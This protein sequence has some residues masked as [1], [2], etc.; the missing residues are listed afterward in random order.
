MKVA[1]YMRVSTVDQHCEVQARELIDYCRR[2]GWEVVADFRDEGISGKANKKRPAQEKLMN[3]AMLHKF[4][5]VIVWKLDRF[6]RSIM[7][8]LE[9]INKL[10]SWGVRF[11]AVSQNID[12]DSSNPT[13]GLLL[14]IM[15]AMAEFERELLIERTNSGLAHAR[16]LGKT[17]GRPRKVFRRDEQ[18]RGTNPATN[19]AGGNGHKNRDLYLSPYLPSGRFPKPF[20]ARI[21]ARSSTCRQSQRHAPMF[22]GW[23]GAINPLQ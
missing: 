16:A 6:G 14:N 18:H 1:L 8:L 19:Q 9:G 23:T 7:N 12:T 15:A 11:M 13:S 4:D 5:A 21:A 10:K 3:D 20:S 17:L 22:V 2:R